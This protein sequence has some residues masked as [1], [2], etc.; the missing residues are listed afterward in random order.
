M[1]LLILQR[2]ALDFLIDILYFP[3]WWYTAGAKQTLLF[4]VDF[5]RVGNSSLAPGLWLRNIFRPMFGQTDWQGR[6]TSFFI[7]LVNVIVRAFLLL[8]WLA[9]TLFMFLLWLVVPM[10]VVYMLFHT[11]FANK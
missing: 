4:F 9:I 10:A 6:I 11:L 1:W 2:V 3:F 7:R 5:F 8:I